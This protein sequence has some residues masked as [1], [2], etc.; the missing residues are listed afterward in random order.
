MRI[1]ITGG[2]TGGH[3]FP[4]IALAE[5]FQDR[6]PQNRIIFVGTRKG[7]EQR[8]I[9]S[10]GYELKTI[11]S[12]GMLG[13]GMLQKFSGAVQCFIGIFQAMMI[14]RIFRPDLVLGTG[15]YVSS[16]VI[17][18]AYLLGIETAIC[19]QNSIPGLSN[20]ILAILAK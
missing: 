15:G 3:L 18:A 2:G 16:P 7:I 5:E 17:L 6:S 13:K 1:L 19:E 12:A 20:R 9:P 14:I 10:M 4:G 8:I 11:S